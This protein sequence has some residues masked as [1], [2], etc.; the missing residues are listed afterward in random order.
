M[1]TNDWKHKYNV[2]ITYERKHR[3]RN[4]GDGSYQQQHFYCNEKMRKVC[5]SRT[6]CSLEKD[7]ICADD[8]IY[9]FAAK[10]L[11]KGIRVLSD[12]DQLLDNVLPSLYEHME[13]LEEKEIVVL[14]TQALKKM[15]KC[16]NILYYEE[17]LWQFK[18]ISS[19]L[20]DVNYL[21][22]EE[23]YHRICAT[24]FI[25]PKMY[26]DILM[27]F[28]YLYANT[29]EPEYVKEVFTLY[30]FEHSSLINNQISCIQFDSVHN[31]KFT[32]L[33]RGLKLEEKLLK[34]DRHVQL[35]TLYINIFTMIHSF[36][37][38][39]AI[40]YIDKAM[41]LAKLY[42][43]HP[44]RLLMLYGNAGTTY[45]QLGEYEK[46][47]ALLK[48]AYE[49]SNFMRVR[50]SLCICHCAHMLKQ[51]IPSTYLACDVAYGDEVD[52]AVYDYFR[53]YSRRDI[54]DNNVYIINKVARI[55]TNEDLLYLRIMAD[56]LLLLAQQSGYYK[57][58][59]GFRKRFSI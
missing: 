37:A 5:S 48:R 28:A 57:T 21:L 39:A 31:H 53:F 54:E 36:D 17:Y 49:T 30:D 46:S 40:S 51:E 16:E 25:F 23:Q 32:A 33:K 26:Q 27:R 19:Y 10:K 6:Y 55:L 8:A 52:K 2:L 59:Y 3:L 38:Q 47:M 41:E 4:K 50:H 18:M 22:T 9:E 14:L 35:L 34:S 1:I 12:I 43:F 11:G 44:N 24:F 7:E 42:Q 15:E 58:Y 13:R 56:E 29:Q 20:D 45:L